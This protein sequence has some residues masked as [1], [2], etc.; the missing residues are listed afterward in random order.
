[1]KTIPLFV[2]ISLI[3]LPL[4][5][6]GATVDTFQG[7][8]SEALAD[9]SNPGHSVIVNLTVPAECYVLNASMS[10]TRAPAQGSYPV[11]PEVLLNGTPLW[12]FNRTGYGA[13]GKQDQFSN[14]AIQLKTPF[15]STGGSGSTTIRLPK[16]A[17]VNN[18]TMELNASGPA[19]LSELL[20]STGIA[21]YDYFGSSVSSAG[22]VNNDGYD[23]FIAGT[24]PSSATGRAY[25]YLGGPSMDNIADVTITGS[26]SY[27]AFGNSVS[28]A[29][30]VNN[31]GYDD[32]IVG[33]YGY[34]AIYLGGL[35]MNNV[36][37]V[38]LI[39]TSG[40][41]FGI[42]SGAGDVNADGY[43][44]IIVGAAGD[45]T[46]GT[47][48]GRAYLFLG[49]QA[50]D[51]TPDVTFTGAA[52][53]DWYGCAVSGAGDV[54]KDGYSDVI[55]GAYYNDAGGNGAGRA[56]LYFG[57]PAVDN[58]ADVTIT[59]SAPSESLGYSVSG[60]GD[61]NKDGYADVIVGIPF[62]SAGGWNSGG[63]NV[64]FGGQTMDSTA[65]VLFA[66][67]AASDFYGCSV[68]RAG[69]VNRD[70]YADVIVGAYQ[71][72]AGGNNV[73]RAYV[74]FGGQAMDT[75]SDLS[76]TGTTADDW[77]GYSVSGAGDMNGDGYDEVAVGA[78]RNDAAGYNA[79]RAYV[80]G[81]LVGIQ[82][83][84]VTLGAVPIWN[85]PGYFN[86]TNLTDNFSAI[87]NG[88]L[89]SATPSGT[90]GFG[91]SYVDVP[92]NVSGNSTG[93]LTLFNLNV[94]YLYSTT[95]PD[96]ALP[97]NSYIAAHRSG[98]DAGMNLTVPIVVRSQ[99][100]GA[101]ELSDL[102]I[103]CDGAPRLIGDLPSLEMD[104][105]TISGNLLDLWIYLEDEYTPGSALN[106]SIVNATNSS[107]VDIGVYDGRNLTAD[108]MTGASNDN[109]TGTV[110]FRVKATDAHGLSVLS[111]PVTLTVKNVN[112]APVITSTPPLNA[113]VGVEYIY[114]LA[115]FDGDGDKVKF[116]R[117]HVPD[118]MTVSTDGN[119]SWTPA[120]PGD[121]D[122][123]LMVTDD[124]RYYNYQNFS[125]NVTSN[126]PGNRGPMFTSIPVS[127]ASVDVQYIYLSNAT[128]PDNDVLDFSLNVAA[129]GMTINSSTGAL[130]WVPSIVG[131]Y[132]VSISVFDGTVRVYQ[133]FTITV[134]NRPPSF[135]SAPV[136]M[137]MVGEPYMYDA[138]ATDADAQTLSYNLSEG[139]AGMVIIPLTGQILWTPTTQQFG[140]ARVTIRTSDGFGGTAE[141]SFN[142]T[143]YGR[144]VCSIA[145][146]TVGA[147]VGSKLVVKG[148]ANGGAPAIT[149]V[150][151]RL[152]G[153]SW[154]TA[155]GTGNWSLTITSGLSKTGAHSVEARAF[156]GV[157]YSDTASA[158]CYVGGNDNVTT[159]SAPL[160]AIIA[161]I[162]VVVISVG[163]I[164]RMRKN[165]T[166]D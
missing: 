62:S 102:K 14:G 143:V 6:F 134:V 55:V 88:Y 9:L 69:D 133:N 117:R 77:C 71:N 104:E 128:D 81:M 72:D 23:D 10:V 58:A 70:G 148:T 113:T 129:P 46:G 40:D 3:S 20:L 45:D 159:E 126:G 35:P 66:G 109:W 82:S 144:P 106:F 147:K 150:Q 42:V 49:G 32:V 142:I 105:D 131:T 79:G 11:C 118:N 116:A 139:P 4:L 51:S 34:A 158:T 59:G 80:Y 43:D 95:V 68:S 73:G 85:N 111:N 53:G 26:G 2:A 18:A 130:S 145:S 120:R 1:M 75:A 22:D 127:T 5:A 87:L 90:D 52:A 78:P 146:P 136:G 156:D 89:G 123:S 60:A 38:T 17:S 13:L 44:D 165:K 29:G 97:L 98:K 101:L 15:G 28:C 149:L 161:V 48:A 107:I 21:A 164:F 163:V 7:G 83:S 154:E 37:D 135:T 115:A 94:T 110:E 56:Y 160:L 114:R 47:D 93:N 124:G 41:Y 152:D 39:G 137:A 86:G 12:A 162:I 151:V 122:V 91:N 31:D 125:I 30:D 57:G 33:A 153:G 16:T 84:S 96:F 166:D 140:A 74:Y 157:R 138:N 119:V 50:M 25:I 61:V 92:I 65:D 67:A 24:S 155:T 63:A 76:V 121:F 103:V 108:A 100:S 64:Y 8:A 19:K 141:Q 54:N 132:N 36:A 112:D 99:S 27:N